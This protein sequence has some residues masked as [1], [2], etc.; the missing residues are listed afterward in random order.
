LF[1]L[2]VVTRNEIGQ[3]LKLNSENKN[4][5]NEANKPNESYWVCIFA[6]DT[7]RAALTRGKGASVDDIG[8]VLLDLFGRLGERRPGQSHQTGASGFEDTEGADK[9]E[10]GV[11]TGRLRGAIEQVSK[12][13]ETK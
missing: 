8:G 10:E 6:L 3:T 11:D 12:G 1:D 13:W 7:P 2:W 9:L 5:K 4:E